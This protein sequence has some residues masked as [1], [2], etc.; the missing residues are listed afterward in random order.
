MTYKVTADAMVLKNSSFNINLG[1]VVMKYYYPTIFEPMESNP[2][3]FVI[4]VPDV[5][6]CVSQGYNLEECMYMAHDA[7]GCML[8]GIDTSNYPKP[9]N[10]N[11]ID[12]SEYPK[13]SFVTL[14]CFDKDKYDADRNKIRFARKKAGLNIKQLAELIGAPYR[15]VQDWNNG[16]RKPPI[17]LQNL[18]VEKIEASL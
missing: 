2:N 8:D 4:I 11:D 18:I 7:I 10:T 1:G 6:G 12:I 3:G 9:S 14:V 16:K 17:W 5:K 15:T 13:G